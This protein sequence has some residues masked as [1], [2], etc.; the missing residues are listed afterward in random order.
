MTRNL[1]WDAGPGEIRAG[2]T[3][4]GRLSAFRLIRLRRDTAL[5][6]AGERYT[7]QIISKLG[8]GQALVSIGGGVQALMRPCPALT[9][10]ARVEV[11]MVR[12]PIPEPG[13]WK[14]AMVRPVEVGT[15]QA[16]AGW[17][18]SAEPWETFLQHSAAGMD[19]I[20]CPDAQTANEV[21][22]L[23]GSDA[24]DIIVDAEAIADADFDTLIEQAV[25]GAFP[26]EDGIL[27]IERTRAMTMIDIDGTGA[28]LALNLAAA[29]AIP[30]LLQLLDIGGPV[31][32]DFVSM[33]SRAD[34]LAVDQAL[35]DGA[36]DLGPY[37]KT[38]TNGYGFCQMIRPKAR[39][40]VPEILCGTT[41]GR[42]SAE[43]LAIA[44]LRAAGR[45]QGIGARR[46]VARPAIIDLIRAW[47]EEVGALRASLGVAIELV[48]DASVS[49][50]GHVHVEQG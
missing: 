2:L 45:S 20:I 39:P 37:E 13:R 5:L 21:G 49:G 12:A 9:D 34:R 47:P 14:R 6:A 10:G 43:S 35:E 8:G 41:P 31:G 25:I 46:L 22:Q 30:H 40:S 27:T 7:A 29:Q 17:H 42:L 15:P 4:D 1:L 24:P 28:P 44:L 48:P 18:F 26:I 36:A 23:L 32:I 19:A 3:L 33:G 38:A 50:Y 16:E 11:E